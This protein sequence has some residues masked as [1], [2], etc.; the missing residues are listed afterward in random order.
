MATVGRYK[1][2][3]RRDSPGGAPWIQA[4]TTCRGARGAGAV[5]ETRPRV[6][7]AGMGVLRAGAILVLLVVVGLCP[8]GTPAAPA[9]ASTEVTDAVGDA[10]AAGD[11]TAVKVTNDNAGRITFDVALANRP[12]LDPLEVIGIY[13]VTDPGAGTGWYGFDYFVVYSGRTKRTIL[14]RWKISTWEIV[15]GDVPSMYEGGLR[16]TIR[17]EDIGGVWAFRFGVQSRRLVAPRDVDSVPEEPWEAS[18]RIPYEIRT[19]LSLESFSVAPRQPRRGRAVVARMQLTADPAIAGAP[20]VTCPATLG[21]KR[22][23][24]IVSLSVTAPTTPGGRAI[25]A[26]TC[27]WKPDQRGMLRGRMSVALGGMVAARP[28]ATRVR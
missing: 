23:Q 24:G 5:D 1:T 17:R 16:A 8:A 3:R 28:V 20:K 7:S 25:V 12:Q 18:V 10:G 15:D 26:S 22:L 9:A 11:I 21:G 6:H 4:T 14:Y 27:R 19:P 13:L 2:H